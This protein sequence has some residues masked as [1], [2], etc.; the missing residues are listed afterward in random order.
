MAA[1]VD[2]HADFF[3]RHGF[4]LRFHLQTEQLQHSIGGYGKQPDHRA[5]DRRDGIYH[6]A[7]KAGYLERLLHGDP[8]GNQFAEY[9]GKVRQND[10]RQYR[11]NAVHDPFRNHRQPQSIDAVHNISG[12]AVRREC[13]AQEAGQG[14]GD[15]NGRQERRRCLYHLQKP[16]RPF[17]AFL[18]QLL[19]LSRVQGHNRDLRSGEERVQSDQ[20]N[21]QQ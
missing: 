13:T 8:L 4:L 20:D 11:G 18:F 12:K 6:A 7:G 16:L 9:Q 15:L 5:H 1:Q 19:Q 3:L 17:V 2:H 14:N 10:G 21:L